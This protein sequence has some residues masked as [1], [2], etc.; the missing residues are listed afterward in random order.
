MN[1]KN[2]I[3]CG[4]ELDKFYYSH[5]ADAFYLTCY[6][7]NNHEVTFYNIDKKH[8][9]RFKYSD[10]FKN[11]FFG[12]LKYPRRNLTSNGYNFRFFY[13]SYSEQNIKDFQTYYE[14]LKDQEILK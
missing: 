13:P 9:V 3:V 12:E 6:I 4:K 14:L 1:P 2:C 5:N 10:L 7:E 8:Y 11:F